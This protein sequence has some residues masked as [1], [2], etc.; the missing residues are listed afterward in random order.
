[1]NIRF[2]TLESKRVY[3]S[4]R[5]TI[6][7]L[8]FPVVFFVVVAH[9]YKGEL[10]G[11]TGREYLM[12]AMAVF[13]GMGA[14]INAG[15][16]IA[17]ERQIGWNRVLRLTPLTSR[18]YLRAK[19]VTALVVALPS[20]LLVFGAGALFEG[21]HLSAAQWVHMVSNFLIALIPFAVLGVALGYVATGDSAQAMSGAVLM[22]MSLFGGVWIPVESMPRVLADFAQWLPPY[23]LGVA[24]RAPISDQQVGA[25]GAA[26]LAAWAAALALFAASRYRRD[27]ARA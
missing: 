16:R 23:W 4:T 26:V 20:I 12:T 10:H 1:M 6:F 9:Q 18:Q 19:L 2:L 21:I 11:V 25:A 5:F 22:L 24:A 8:I 17:I 13:G 7:T 14:T 27:A 3:R 15:A